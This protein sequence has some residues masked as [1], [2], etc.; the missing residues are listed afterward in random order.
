MS[1]FMRLFNEIIAAP[2][3]LQGWVESYPIETIYML[4][5]S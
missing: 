1:N 3:A 4:Q 5:N 2:V